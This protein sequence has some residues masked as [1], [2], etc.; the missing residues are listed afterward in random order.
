ML[1]SANTTKP[2]IRFLCYGLAKSSKGKE[3]LEKTDPTD[4]SD[5]FH[6]VDSCNDFHVQKMAALHL[7]NVIRKNFFFFWLNIAVCA[8]ISLSGYFDP[9]KYW[10]YSYYYYY[11]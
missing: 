6:L 4:V 9:P 11:Y 1:K 10:P 2:Q 5:A 3:T 8:L 7:N